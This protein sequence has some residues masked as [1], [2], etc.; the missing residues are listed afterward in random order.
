MADIEK[1]IKG[2]EVCFDS[3]KEC[4]GCPYIAT[5]YCK[6]TLRNDVTALLKEQEAE[7]VQY[8]TAIGGL[9]YGACPQCGDRVD[10]LLN[11]NACGFCG[12]RLDWEGR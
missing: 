6:T 1:V 5:P 7:K 11:P 12:Q 10:N 9:R 3:S 4:N 2:L 8:T